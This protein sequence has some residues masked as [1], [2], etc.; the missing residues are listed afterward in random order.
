MQRYFVYRL[1]IQHSIEICFPKMGTQE[2]YLKSQKIFPL[3]SLCLI[4][5]FLAKD[6]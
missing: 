2:N 3:G 1:K 6:I 5:K 4:L